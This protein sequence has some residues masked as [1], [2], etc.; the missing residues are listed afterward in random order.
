M[1]Y[2]NFQ[3]SAIYLSNVKFLG[4]KENAYFGI[5]VWWNEQTDLSIV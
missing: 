4:K 2:L 1:T 5:E 3:F